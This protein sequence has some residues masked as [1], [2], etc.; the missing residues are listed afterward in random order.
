MIKYAISIR[1]YD[2]PLVNRAKC[3]EYLL[4]SCGLSIKRSHKTTPFP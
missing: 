4:E 3:H 2:L 1:L